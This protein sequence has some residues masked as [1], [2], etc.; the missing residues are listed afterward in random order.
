MGVHLYLLGKGSNDVPL[1]ELFLWR[2]REKSVGVMATKD[3]HV[4]ASWRGRLGT[5]R[6][7]NIRGA[8]IREKDRKSLSNK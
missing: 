5:G 6:Q 7:L 8:V 2:D 4:S 3:L 1:S